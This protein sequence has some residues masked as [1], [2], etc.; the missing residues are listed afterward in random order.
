MLLNT[1]NNTKEIIHDSLFPLSGCTIQ[2]DLSDQTDKAQPSIYY[3]AQSWSQ[4]LQYTGE[5]KQT[6][7]GWHNGLWT[8]KYIESR[9]HAYTKWN[10]LVRKGQ[11][12]CARKEAL[13]T[14]FW[15]PPP[16]PHQVKMGFLLNTHSLTLTITKW[17]ILII[18]PCSQIS[19]CLT[20]LHIQLRET[21]YDKWCIYKF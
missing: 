18:D 7:H 12:N 16:P 6:V 14:R 3:F 9:I 4:S 15:T 8:D 1:Q 20:L 11:I 17:F 5:S 19:L 13:L 21:T 2:L 10:K